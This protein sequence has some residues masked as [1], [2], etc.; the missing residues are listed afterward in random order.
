MINNLKKIFNMPL[1]AIYLRIVDIF[2]KYL[3]LSFQQISKK[4]I[5][6]NIGYKDFEKLIE[7]I[8][9]REVPASFS[10]VDVNFYLSNFNNESIQLKKN[11]EKVLKGI[12][13]ILGSGDISIKSLDWHRDYKSGYK[14]PNIPFSKIDTQML[15]SSS[16][17]KFP[18]ELSRM[19]WLMPLSQS[20]F[21][22]KDDKYADHLKKILTSW[23]NKNKCGYGPN[24]SCTMEPSIRAITFI[25]FYYLCKDSPSWKD[26]KFINI[27]LRSVFEHLDFISKHVEISDINGNHLISNASALVI[28]GVF[29]GNKSKALKWHNLGWKI[30]E[31]E[32]DRQIY[33]D[34]VSFEGS[35]SYHRLVTELIFLANQ[36]NELSTKKI[37][38]RFR[39]KLLKM[40]TYIK[41]Y[42]RNDNSSPLIGDSDDG[43]A[44]NFGGN[45][46]DHIYLSNSIDILYGGGS[47]YN[48]PSSYDESAWWLGKN[49]DFKIEEYKK[50][51]G[52]ISYAFN[53]GGSYIIKQNDN[54]IFI[55]C[56]PVGLS[57]RGG[58][59]HNDCLSFT[60]TI[61]GINIVTDP[62]SYVYTS[63]IKMRQQLRSTK[64]HNTPMIADTEINS[65][66]SDKHIWHL[67]GEAFP[68]LIQWQED[69]E[70][71]YFVGSHS[72]Y[73]KLNPSIKPIRI[74]VY[75]KL[76][77]QLALRDCFD[78]LKFSHN[79]SIPLH[80][81]NDIRIKEHKNS[82]M[83]K[84]NNKS[85]EFIL[86]WT[87]DDWSINK[88]ETFT[89]NSYG[90]KNN[91]I[92]LIWNSKTDE[93]NPLT[94]YI[95]NSDNYTSDN[96]DR[97][98]N[99]LD[100]IKLKS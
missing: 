30:L 67:K 11:A 85:S 36:S 99:V 87:N 4:N 9:I 53:K 51:N 59:G 78:P 83:L 84:L 17:I 92:K 75:D 2:Y 33:P 60:A 14:W 57:N 65:F 25:I 8:N 41:F 7:D 91:S 21:L 42:S 43:R 82:N 32:L 15:D 68:S 77:H 29:L 90:I 18:W 47:F 28:G 40:G 37:N 94:V 48:R 46:N 98:C 56:G 73:E 86:F 13:N 74:I 27:F 76:N 63:D 23:I 80:L 69:D 5:L 88:E 89:S 16:D 49:Y 62:G 50:E 39:N 24:W 64:S 6:K 31:Y 61:N 71:V 66:I 70:F 35:L 79:V 12:V 1:W 44:L 93:K 20:W 97:L 95:T 58:H 54:H 19:Q 10:G 34:G 26:A 45:I 38:K 22:Y 96:I 55:D 52:S 100:S 3:P 72:G 81:A